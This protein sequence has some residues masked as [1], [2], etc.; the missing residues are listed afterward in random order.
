MGRMKKGNHL[1][2]EL[3]D[4]FVR[5]K[6]YLEYARTYLAPEQ[7]DRVDEAA[8]LAIVPDP[9]ELPERSLREQR[10]ADFLP[11]YRELLS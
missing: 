10:W 8:L 5:S 3:F 7:I 6:V 9:F 4:E 2:P 11:Q 1:D